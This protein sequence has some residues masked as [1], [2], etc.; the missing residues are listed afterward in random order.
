M[1]RIRKLEL[2]GEGIQR[3]GQPV[4][5]S[6][7]ESVVRN[8]GGSRPPVTLGHPKKGDDKV[9]A[10]GRIDVR[11]ISTNDKGEAVLLCE[12]HYTP[13]LEELEDQGKFEGQSAGI[14]PLPGKPGE[15]YLHHVAQLGSLPPAANIKT[16]D[17]VELSDDGES[18]AIFLFSN[19]GVQTK[20]LNENSIMKFEDLMKAVKS[21]SDDEKKQLGDALGFKAE[22]APSEGELPTNGEPGDKGKSNPEGEENEE[23][24]QMRESMAGDRRETLTELA[25]DASLGEDM[26]KVIT[27]MIKGASAIE[28]CNTGEGSRYSEIKS[29][30]K[31]Q[32]AKKKGSLDVFGDIELSNEGEEKDTFDPEG[33]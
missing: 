29:L 10:L 16:L 2:V 24:K 32:P 9:P 31:A 21:Y 13:E 20:Q 1:P 11:G 7:L 19:A 23:L 14:Y 17:V 27:S 22:G 33:W 18:D 12:Q 30:I 3:N 4:D 15:F 26:L 8:S 5:K 6:V 28:L 25:N